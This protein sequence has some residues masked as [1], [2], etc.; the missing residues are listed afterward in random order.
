MQK[1]DVSKL[2][3]VLNQIGAEN[4]L[5]WSEFYVI[6]SKGLGDKTLEENTKE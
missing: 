5:T 4:G 2:T 1:R 6:C 3:L